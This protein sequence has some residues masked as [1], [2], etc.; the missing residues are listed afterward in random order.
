[1]A[2][3]TMEIA[4]FKAALGLLHCQVK[5][6]TYTPT[7][8]ADL[9]NLAD[10][11]PDINA[12][13]TIDRKNLRFL[14]GVQPLFKNK[15]RAFGACWDTQNRKNQ[16]E[17]PYSSRPPD[18]PSLSAH[19]TG[20]IHADCEEKAAT[21]SRQLGFLTKEK[22]KKA[23][24]IVKLKATIRNKTDPE[25]N[26]V[27]E[28]VKMKGVTQL[29]YGILQMS[30][31][32]EEPACPT[33]HSWTTHKRHHTKHAASH[34]PVQAEEPARNAPGNSTPAFQGCPMAVELL[35]KQD[36]V[37]AACSNKR[38]RQEFQAASHGDPP[39]ENLVFPIA[40]WAANFTL[41][42]EHETLETALKTVAASHL[43]GDKLESLQMWAW[44]IQCELE[45]LIHCL[46]LSITVYQFCLKQQE[47][48]TH[49][50]DWLSST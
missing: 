5:N 25:T 50:I 27:D 34:S 22:L 6:G 37:L 49:K 4:H 14:E 24:K 46:E 18:N 38:L 39:K 3:E 32:K 1:M 40:S 43:G 23:G 7:I 28:D 33:T 35:E 12:I 15:D 20:W 13:L 30:L 19:A 8:P 26:H 17:G 29:S 9:P 10:G 41:T 36:Q 42:S 47:L 48:I 2:S 16:L 31:D 21:I 11:I 45:L 44:Q